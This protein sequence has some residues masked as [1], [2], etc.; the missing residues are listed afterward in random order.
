MV[1]SNNHAAQAFYAECGFILTG[2][3][4]PYE[5]DAALFEYEMAK[6]F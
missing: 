6:A 3:T 5:N 1:T 2:I 4:K